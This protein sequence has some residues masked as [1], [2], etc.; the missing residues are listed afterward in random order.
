MAR[1]GHKQNQLQQFT[2]Q[3]AP[4]YLQAITEGFSNSQTLNKFSFSHWFPTFF[5]LNIFLF[6]EYLNPCDE[7]KKHRI[8]ELK[9]P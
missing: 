3:E 8:L 7:P 4:S 1:I 2:S 5:L 9:G 6:T